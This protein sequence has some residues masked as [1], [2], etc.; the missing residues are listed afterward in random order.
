M[1]EWAD[2]MSDA[3]ISQDGCAV[4]GSLTFLSDLY[5]LELTNQMAKLLTNNTAVPKGWMSP[6]V[7]R[8]HWTQ[9]EYYNEWVNYDHIAID[10]ESTIT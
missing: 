4:C 2:F 6:A 9:D 3:K 10:R 5:K 1:N 7:T 8:Y